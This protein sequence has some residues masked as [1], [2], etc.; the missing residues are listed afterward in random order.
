MK[1]PSLMKMVK[2]SAVKNL[3]FIKAKT[4]E[5]NPNAKT[6]NVDGK[7]MPIKMKKAPA[8]MYDKK[9]P[10]KK[11][12][13]DAQRKAVHASKADKGSPAKKYGKSPMREDK[14]MSYDDAHTRDF[15]DLT[16]T[17]TSSQ[18]KEKYKEYNREKYGTTEPTRDAKQA[19]LTKK[20][21]G[22]ARNIKPK[23]VTKVEVKAAKPNVKKVKVNEK[24]MKGK[25]TLGDTKLGN[26]KVGKNGKRLADTKIGKAFS[27]G[28]AKGVA[29]R[30]AR[31]ER[32]AAAKTERI[33]KRKA[34]K[35]KK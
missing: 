2:N 8:K 19:G 16:K 24:V 9:S 1:G 21:L 26:L 30:Q 29:A 17:H 12:K 6:M 25:K 3:G 5:K 11:Y 28:R 35:N 14:P 4:L 18:V 27:K 32:M 34:R 10:A 22:V 7:E 23:K 13:S 15:S 33:A 31:A 20:E